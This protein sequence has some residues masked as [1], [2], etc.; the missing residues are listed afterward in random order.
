MAMQ[1]YA[2]TP[3]RLN[4][5]KGQILAHAVPTEVLGK[6]GRQVP[7]PKNNSDTYVAR[8]WLPYGATA[9]D[10]NTITL[11]I[12]AA[13]GATVGAIGAVTGVK[14]L[15]IAGSVIGA[16][17]AVGAIASS[18]GLLGE[19]GSF[20][21]MGGEGGANVAATAAGAEVAKDSGV[22]ATEVANATTAAPVEGLTVGN[23]LQEL[24]QM[25]GS[26]IESA[27]G[28]IGTS[29]SQAADPIATF[30]G[31]MTAH[32]AEQLGL[33]LGQGDSIGATP[34]DAGAGASTL[35]DNAAAQTAEAS[36]T[37][38]GS[39]GS[40]AAPD[41]SPKNL[42]NL[43]DPS[44]TAPVNPTAT[45]GVSGTPPQAVTGSAP[46][47]SAVS[48]RP[49]PVMGAPGQASAA[50]TP[51]GQASAGGTVANVTGKLTAGSSSGGGSA[52]SGIL[53]FLGKPNTLAGSLLQ[54]GSAFVSGATSS[55]TPAQVSAYNAQA[56]AN[57]AQ[58]NL[59]RQQQQL[60]QT[61]MANASAVPTA[62][63]RPGGLINTPAPEGTPQAP[64]APQAA[65]QP[66]PQQNTAYG[67][68]NS[69]YTR[70]QQITGA[71]A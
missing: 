71:P 6:T 35:S 2:L 44:S 3:G 50:T 68:I 17:G 40:G 25:A 54:A 47:A 31:E 8:R 27:A 22:W 23:S 41:A 29:I 15:Q 49:D 11:A 36:K 33:P 4:R 59:A 37:V 9:V 43:P 5:Y 21:G 32:Q 45:G 46:G 64:P 16:I 1:N 18:T 69:A 67:L 65:G 58:A 38:T 13:V 42:V 70:P 52:V 26:G 10:A 56:D 39:V 24:S 53:D 19:V 51:A 12:V 55:L 63:R 60:L 61:Q 62:T 34:V 30:S 66:Q 57:L 14:E 28:E 20:L 48:G 7:M